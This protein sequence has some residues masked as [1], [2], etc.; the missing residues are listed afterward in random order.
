M[1]TWAVK[2]RLTKTY[3]IWSPKCNY[4]LLFLVS[5]PSPLFAFIRV[6]SNAGPDDLVATIIIIIIPLLMIY[7]SFLSFP[8]F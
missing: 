5:C 1:L 3:L 7:A 6:M 2:S 4:Y 8:S